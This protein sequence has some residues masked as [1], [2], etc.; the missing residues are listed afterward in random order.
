V[1]AYDP[2]AVRCASSDAA[3][4]VKAACVVVASIDEMLSSTLFEVEG[5]L[6]TSV[7]QPPTAKAAMERPTANQARLDMR[8]ISAGRR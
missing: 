7:R 2:V 1:P 3:A 8:E 5:V 6:G 4:P